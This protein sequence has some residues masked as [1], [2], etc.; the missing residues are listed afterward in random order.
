MTGEP[1]FP[2]SVVR[3]RVDRGDLRLFLRAAGA[4]AERW[5]CIHGPGPRWLSWAAICA[6]GD[7]VLLVDP[8]EPEAAD[9]FQ[10]MYAQHLYAVMTA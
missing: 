9:E 6:L 3:V 4:G 7:T 5:L 10:E 8:N 1:F 2:M